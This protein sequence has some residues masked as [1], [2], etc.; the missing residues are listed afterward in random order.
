MV[1]KFIYNVLFYITSLFCSI[2]LF[3]QLAR[4]VNPKIYPVKFDALTV[5]PAV[6]SFLLAAALLVIT[7]FINKKLITR[8]KYNPKKYLIILVT[9][10]AV[11]RIA[12]VTLIKNRQVSDFKIYH[13]FA[14]SLC[15]GTGFSYT[16][17]YGD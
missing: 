9:L 16:G 1:K 17:F 6:F 8:V 5:Y 7:F 11:F 15:N 14:V 10:G 3:T 4:L 2:I 13:E 12:S